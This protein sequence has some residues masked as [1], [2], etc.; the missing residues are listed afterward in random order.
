MLLAGS[1]VPYD[2]WLA[3]DFLRNPSLAC[4]YRTIVF[5]GF[6]WINDS[7]RRLIE[8]LKRDGRTLVFLSGTGAA[9]GVAATGFDV[10]QEEAP[11]DHHV[12]AEPGVDENMISYCDV[13][14]RLRY[15]GGNP[16]GYWKPRRISVVEKPGVKVLAR[17]SEG[18]KPAVAEMSGPEWKSV[19]ICDAAGLTPQYFNS[20][21]RE[22]G[23]YAPA[24]Y[25]LQVDMNAGFLS[26]HC[27]IPGRYEFRLPR[28]CRV[29][30][31]GDGRVVVN[32][33]ETLSLDL[34]VGDTLW[35]ALL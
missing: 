22:S 34:K 23:G 24:P 30:D 9:G 12:V 32:D 10:V 2:M 20:L 3:A 25:G 15:L 27:I 19:Y 7:R 8:S 35:F 11:K 5:C 33:D 1:G 16:A 28:K 4:R 21:V 18:G 26:V 29:R 6:S 17:F 14:V 31:L 13:F